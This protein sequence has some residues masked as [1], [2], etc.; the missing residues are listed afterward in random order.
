MTKRHGT[1]HDFLG[2]LLRLELDHQHALAGAGDDE[3]EP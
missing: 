2:Q 3:V 1:Q